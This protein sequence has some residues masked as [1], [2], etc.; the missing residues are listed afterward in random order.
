VLSLNYDAS[1]LA[2]GSVVVRSVEAIF[3]DGLLAAAGAD[4]NCP[5]DLNLKAMAAESRAPLTTIH[6]VVPLLKSMT[7]RGDLARYN[8]VEG[9]PAPDENT[10]EG[11]LQIPRLR[12]RL[13]L[14]AGDIAPARFQSLPLFRVRPSGDGF[15]ATDYIPP[16]PVV[17]ISSALGEWICS[18]LAD[19]RNKAYLLAEEARS[20][21]SAQENGDAQAAAMRVH[22]LVAALPFAEAL[23]QSGRAHPLSLYLALVN[24]AGQMS[25][26]DES[27]VPP[28][29]EPYKHDELRA[30]YEPV[31]RYV[32]R[33]AEEAVADQW[34]RIPFQLIGSTFQVESGPILDRALRSTATAEEPVLA[35]AIRPP[36]GVSEEETVTWGENCVIGTAGIVPALLSSRVLGAP[37]RAVDKLPGLAAPRGAYLFTLG[38]DATALRPGEALQML[39][40]LNPESR[41]AQAI[42]FIRRPGDSD[43][44]DSI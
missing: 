9:E 1:A 41:P 6:L 10:G 33:I 42:L 7:T 14:W 28:Y 27:L 13:A 24:L 11:P 8:S 31:L 35:F 19:I 37:R 32:K 21:N 23:L 17:A 29:F 3:Q 5:L 26:L 2:A 38:T 44:K 20:G 16:T 30:T 18:T 25:A 43:S 40:N 22:R 15:A 39:E 36:A 34:H 12:P 4:L